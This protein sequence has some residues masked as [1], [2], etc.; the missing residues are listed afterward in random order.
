MPSYGG[1]GKQFPPLLFL[2][3]TKYLPFLEPREAFILECVYICMYVYMYIR[4]YAYKPF[5]FRGI[6]KVKAQKYLQEASSYTR[7]TT[8]KIQYIYICFK[9]VVKNLGFI[10]RVPLELIG[11]RN[12]QHF[13]KHPLCFHDGGR[14]RPC[15]EVESNVT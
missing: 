2:F 13:G 10:F 1:R 7:R 4:M 5:C 6:L 15:S 12:M 9:T 14:Q 3:S 8:W 11:I